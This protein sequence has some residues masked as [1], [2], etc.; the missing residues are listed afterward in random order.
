MPKTTSTR[1]AST[2][3]TVTRGLAAPVPRFVWLRSPR[4]FTPHRPTR[5]R[6]DLPCTS[7]GEPRTP[8]WRSMLTITNTGEG[9]WPPPNPPRD[10]GD[11]TEPVKSAYG[12]PPGSAPPPLDRTRPVPG[13]G[14]YRV[15][16]RSGRVHRRLTWK[17][18]PS[19]CPE[20]S[21][22]SG[23]EQH[24][25]DEQQGLASITAVGASTRNDLLSGRSRVRV[26]VGAHVIWS[27]QAI[28]HQPVYQA[29][30]APVPL[31]CQMA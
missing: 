24:Q 6:Q 22:T 20:R 9:A 23:I 3:R 31:A 19:A 26:A 15:G 2:R 25:D 12:V 4:F 5:T 1:A 30:L 8:S 7:A 10:D 14:A 13:F 29:H 18:V 16:G 11:R 27:G 28:C 17:R 21:D